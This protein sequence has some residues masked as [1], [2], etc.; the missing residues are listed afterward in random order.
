M[1]ISAAIP[2]HHLSRSKRHYTYS[3]SQKSITFLNN[4]V[5]SYPKIDCDSSSGADFNSASDGM[6]IMFQSWIIT[7]G[8]AFKDEHPHGAFTSPNHTLH[9]KG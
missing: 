2:I 5:N 4:F 7:T 8:W 6:Q 3:V 9:S 1:R